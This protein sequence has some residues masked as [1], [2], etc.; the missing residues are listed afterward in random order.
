MKIFHQIDFYMDRVT[1]DGQ[2][3]TRPPGVTPPQWQMF[4]EK[5]RALNK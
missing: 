5:V 1:L 4:W 3:L 2:T